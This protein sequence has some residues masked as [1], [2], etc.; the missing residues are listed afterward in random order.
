MASLTL[1]WL[2]LAAL[3][4]AL[5]GLLLSGV[6]VAQ[7]SNKTA[8]RLLAALMAAFTIYLASTVYFSRESS[9]R[10]RT[11]SASATRCRGSSGRWSIC[12]RRGE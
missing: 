6:L 9:T 5:Q 8:N 2:Q 1:D 12:T 10:T 11:S 7:R 4:G 3:V